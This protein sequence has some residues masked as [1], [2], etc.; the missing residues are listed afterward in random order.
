MKLLL[1]S[2]TFYISL[3]SSFAQELPKLDSKESF[4]EYAANLK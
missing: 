2:V 3:A 1:M 4:E